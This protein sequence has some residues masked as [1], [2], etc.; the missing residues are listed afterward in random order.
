MNKSALLG[1]FVGV[2]SALLALG[3]LPPCASGQGVSDVNVIILLRLTGDSRAMPQI[4]SCLTSK[5]SQMPDVEI[6]SG[7]TDGA[8]F[9]V[10]I[11][12]ERGA[13]DGIYAS[14]V[15]AETFP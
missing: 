9:V 6:A 12:A 13:D 8:Q 11:I 14:L 7:R 3:S 1:S 2:A 5:L 4:R 15:I 10:D